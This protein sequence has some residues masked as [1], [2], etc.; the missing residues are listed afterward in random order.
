MVNIIVCFSSKIVRCE[1][2][3]KYINN[4]SFLFV[5]KV[6]SIFKLDNEKQFENR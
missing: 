4:N 5:F 6:H 1:Y 3:N 2:I